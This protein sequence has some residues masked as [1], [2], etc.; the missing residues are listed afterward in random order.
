MQIND[1]R[2]CLSVV[3]CVATMIFLPLLLTRLNE[4]TRKEKGTIQ[5][6]QITVAT[7]NGRFFL[8][9][10]WWKI[11]CL[12]GHFNYGIL[13]QRICYKNQFRIETLCSRNQMDG[14]IR[15]LQMCVQL[16]IAFARK[17]NPRPIGIAFVKLHTKSSARAFRL[18]NAK[19]QWAARFSF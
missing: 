3:H 1:N 17:M 4:C 19:N 13:A 15:T 18:L 16:C 5:S 6:K 12:F 9:L 2:F 10:I 7:E 14:N 11:I 8:L